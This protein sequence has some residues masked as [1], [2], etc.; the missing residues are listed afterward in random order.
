[1]TLL[2]G[3]HRSTQVMAEEDSEVYRLSYDRFGKRCREN[4]GV[5][6][7]ML[8]NLAVVLSHRL[9]VRSEEVRML[10]DV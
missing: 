1:M 8:Q 10:E 3:N 5:A 2:D 6:I 4:S 9:R 7:K